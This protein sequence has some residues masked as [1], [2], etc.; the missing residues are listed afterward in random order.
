MC[1]YFNPSDNHYMHYYASQ[2]SGGGG[3]F[4]PVSGLVYQ[5]NICILKG[6]DSLYGA[7]LLHK[8]VYIIYTSMTCQKIQSM[9]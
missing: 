2:V 5:V 4:Q 9:I 6:L 1:V 8:Q 3:E 7:F